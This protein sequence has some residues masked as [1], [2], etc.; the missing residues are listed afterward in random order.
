MM[1]HERVD[2]RHEHGTH[3]RVRRVMTRPRGR[4]RSKR[5]FFL[6]IFFTKM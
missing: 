4:R 5:L 6:F 3:F 1:G 2:K